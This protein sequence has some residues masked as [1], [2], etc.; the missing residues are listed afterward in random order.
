[1]DA[2]RGAD[3]KSFSCMSGGNG[4]TTIT[5]IASTS[6]GGRTWTPEQL[7]SD[8][9]QPQLS[10]ISCP[11]VNECWVSG[12]A[13]ISQRVGSGYDGGS[14]VLIGTTDSGSSWSKVIF[15]VPNGSPNFDGQ[16]FLSAAFISCPSINDCAANGTGAQGAPNSPI[17]TL[18]VPSNAT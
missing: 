1:M 5:D 15:S 11:S 14:S 3:S 12:S 10:G 18:R 16:S 2:Y 7:P 13:A 6:N 17:Y 9:P 4:E 8:V